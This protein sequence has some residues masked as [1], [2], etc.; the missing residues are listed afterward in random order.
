M[1]IACG[2]VAIFPDDILVGDAEGVVVIPADLVAEIA[3]ESIEMTIF[4]DFVM[5]EVKKGAAVIGLY[6][7]T[8]PESLQKYEAWKT[9]RKG[10]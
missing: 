6:P 8:Q 9:A 4:E 5:E 1:P 10:M 3:E 7:P 2:D